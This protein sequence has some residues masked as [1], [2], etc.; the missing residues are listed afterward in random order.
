MPC[1][2]NMNWLSSL[3]CTAHVQK[4]GSTHSDVNTII[5]KYTYNGYHGCYQNSTVS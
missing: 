2:R 3:E 1:I 4:D 5:P